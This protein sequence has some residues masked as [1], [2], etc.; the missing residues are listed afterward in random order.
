M[1]AISSLTK[2]FTIS[3]PHWYFTDSTD[4]GTEEKVDELLS[5]NIVREND[6]YG[7]TFLI[8]IFIFA[9]IYYHTEHLYRNLQNNNGQR[10]YPMFIAA[11]RAVEFRK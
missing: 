5:N 3:P 1:T 6:V 10:G 4:E 9:Y 8:L 2:E 7:S 11:A